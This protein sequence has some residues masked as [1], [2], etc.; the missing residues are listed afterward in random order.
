MTQN[1]ACALGFFD[2][3]H[4]AHS[5]ILS[6]CASYAQRN[7]LKSIAV[8]FSSSPAEF[9][10]HRVEYI[11]DAEQK[12]ELIL[13][14]GIDALYKLEADRETLSL[15]PEEF[16]K[17]YIVD[18][19]GARA[20][21]CG[22]NYT[23]G[24]NASGD[25]R[26]LTKLCEKYSIE[27][28]VCGRM[29]YEGLPVSSSFVREALGKGDMELAEA[30]L[31]RPFEVRGV[32]SEGK[33]L[34]RTI[35]LPTAN[36]YPGKSFPSLPH[37]V[38]ATRTRV[39]NVPYDSVTNVGVNPTVGDGNLRIETNILDFD[40][41]IYGE[42]IA[43]LFYKR[44]RGEIKFGSVEMLRQQIERDKETT[45]EYFKEINNE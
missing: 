30:L 9:F 21:F 22:F 15:S 28:F 38:Y 35:G 10:G 17:K 12:E 25:T 18:I 16:F 42:R 33:R 2:G 36:I 29:E 5:H 37:G 44:L 6:E 39:G 7:G 24:V 13:S 14:L 11:T 32:V 20:L 23:F 40:G 45:R 43:V 19:L 34:G 41:D 26:L 8:T 4:R 31:S 3:V 1:T 27:L